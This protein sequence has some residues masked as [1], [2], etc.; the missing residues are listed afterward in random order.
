MYF[1]MMKAGSKLKKLAKKNG[2]WGIA[3]LL[4]LIVGI[5]VVIAIVAPFV[6]T[7]SADVVEGLQLYWDNAAGE[8][9][10]T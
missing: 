5:V 1:L 9:F 2:G 7:F 4:A 10:G 3:E 6:K 8:L